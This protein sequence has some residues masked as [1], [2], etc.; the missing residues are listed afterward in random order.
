MRKLLV[1]P[2]PIAKA[3]SAQMRMKVHVMI[4]PV[5]CLKISEHS[6]ILGFPLTPTLPNY[7][8]VHHFTALSAFF[9]CNYRFKLKYLKWVDISTTQNQIKVR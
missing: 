5:S 2:E 6:T 1:P 4:Q 8:R 7:E 3:D 9:S